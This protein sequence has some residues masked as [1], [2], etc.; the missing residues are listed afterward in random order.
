[1]KKF[2]SLILLLSG[3]LGHAQRPT[4]APSSQNNYPIDLNSWFDVLV[5][6]ILPLIIIVLY[7]MWRR[8]VKIDKKKDKDISK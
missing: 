6:I 3:F 7:F 5:F 8:Q 2:K 1:M 4:H